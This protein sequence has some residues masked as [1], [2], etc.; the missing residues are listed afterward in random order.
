MNKAEFIKT[1]T[2]AGKLYGKELDEEVI[3]MWLS[4]F[5]ENTIDEFKQ[6]MNE[7]IKTSKYFPTIADIKELIASKEVATIPK[8]ED[9]WNKVIE[10]VHKY[11]SYQ[12]DKALEEMN[13]YTRY[14]V[15]YIGYIRICNADSDEQTWNKKSFI[16]EYNE[17]KDKEITSLQIGDGKAL[18]RILEDHQKLKN[19]IDS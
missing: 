10:L 2:G 7:H 1:L 17:L 14:I 6:A 5:K 4:F 11:G 13:D 12:M 18:F 16:S 9:E 15:N 3:K 19:L 8:A